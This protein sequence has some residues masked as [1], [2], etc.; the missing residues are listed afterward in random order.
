VLADGHSVGR[1]GIRGTAGAVDPREDPELFDI[2]LANR[3]GD[4][5]QIGSARDRDRAA[6]ARTAGGRG[7]SGGDAPGGGLNQQRERA[8]SLSDLDGTAGVP[9]LLYCKGD[10]PRAILHLIAESDLAAQSGEIRTMSRTLAIALAASAVLAAPATAEVR[11]ERA[12]PAASASTLTKTEAPALVFGGTFVILA[13]V[14]GASQAALRVDSGATDVMLPRTVAARLIRAGSLTHAD[15]VTTKT[16]RLADGSLRTQKVYRL[17]SLKVGALIARDIPCTIS[18]D[19]TGLLG[20][21]FLSKAQDWAMD[22]R[23]HVLTLTY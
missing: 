14:N 10:H 4:G 12:F 17:R 23:R 22:N 8:A 7:G 21:S 11:L 3:D 9:D 18:N 19:D 6:A 20:Q 13:T 2:A 15:Y 16:Y 1:V 5:L